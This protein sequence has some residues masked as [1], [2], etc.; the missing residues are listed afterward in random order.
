MSLKKFFE[1][2]FEKIGVLL[3]Y[4]GQNVTIETSS[5]GKKIINSEAA[6]IGLKAGLIKD[7]KERVLAEIADGYSFVCKNPDIN[8]DEVKKMIKSQA[9]AFKN[10]FKELDLKE[11]E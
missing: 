3:H 11:K 5:F 2:E 8:D 6:F 9:N 1:K 10:I 7:I 4:K